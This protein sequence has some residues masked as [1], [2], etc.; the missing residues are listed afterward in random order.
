MSRAISRVYDRQIV[1]EFSP[2]MIEK[3]VVLNPLIEDAGDVALE[4]K[5]LVELKWSLN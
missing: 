3:M 2:F 4:F 1:S 5:G